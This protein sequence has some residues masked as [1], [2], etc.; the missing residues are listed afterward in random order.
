MAAKTVTWM[1]SH[2]PAR[3]MS[4]HS[5]SCCWRVVACGSRGAELLC[6]RRPGVDRELPPCH[7]VRPACEITPQRPPQQDDMPVEPSRQTPK[8]VPSATQ[9][10]SSTYT[11]ITYP[12]SSKTQPRR[13]HDMRRTAKCGSHAPSD[14][15]RLGGLPAAALLL[16]PRGLPLQPHKCAL[17]SASHPRPWHAQ[18]DEHRVGVR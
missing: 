4:L 14:A 15:C 7:W 2:M 18:Q 16:R 17:V 10:W 5:A 1:T 9:A 8:L 12:C 3:A 13:G 11:D 6:D